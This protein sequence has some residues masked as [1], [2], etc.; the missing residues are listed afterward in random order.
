MVFVL[1]I[2]YYVKVYVIRNTEYAI[3]KNIHT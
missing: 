1:L 3:T 2:A